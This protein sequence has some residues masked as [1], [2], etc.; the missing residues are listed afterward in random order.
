MRIA[1]RKTK[2]LSC[3][4]HLDALSYMTDMHCHCIVLFLEASGGIGWVVGNRTTDTTSLESFT[5]LGIQR[6]Y[7]YD[8]LR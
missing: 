3:N 8:Q 5:L 6:I 1:N 7:R 4:E 2:T